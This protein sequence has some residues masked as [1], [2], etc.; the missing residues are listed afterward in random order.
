MKNLIYSFEWCF[1]ECEFA[2]ILTLWPKVCCFFSSETFFSARERG[3]EEE[4]KRERKRKKRARVKRER[5]KKEQG[6]EAT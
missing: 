1:T 6:E 5:E 2:K 4:G 3:R